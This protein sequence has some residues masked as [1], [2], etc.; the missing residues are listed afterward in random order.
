MTELEISQQIARDRIKEIERQLPRKLM[1]REKNLV[2]NFRKK[3][4]TPI[5]KL[6]KLYFFMDELYDFVAKFTPCK[7][8][9]TA[10]CHIPVYI[11][12]L[13]IEYI[14]QATGIKRMSGFPVSLSNEATG[15]PFLLNNSCTIY[16]VRPYV[17]RS[18]F[19]FD[20][21]SGWCQ[22][23]VCHKVNLS[24]LRFSEVKKTYEEIVFESGLEKW[25]DIREIF[26]GKLSC[27]R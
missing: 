27:R 4:E 15:C 17:C 9:C 26:L 19:A 18:H 16:A 1:I 2:K 24:G 8:G 3:H 13:D 14:E 10:C 25:V 22:I 7:L 11:S 20:K 5:A 12:G 23:D 21:N 6:Q